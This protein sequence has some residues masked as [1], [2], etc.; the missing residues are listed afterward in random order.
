MRRLIV[1][2]MGLTLIG[3]N[4]LIRMNPHQ[5]QRHRAQVCQAVAVAV[6][7]HLRP[8]PPIEHHRL[9]VVIT[10]PNPFDTDNKYSAVKARIDVMR[11]LHRTTNPHGQDILHDDQDGEYGLTGNVQG[12]QVVQRIGHPHVHVEIRRVRP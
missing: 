5:Y 11:R 2:L 9:E 8:R 6:P 4:D 10:L 3:A 12:L 7:R 1:D